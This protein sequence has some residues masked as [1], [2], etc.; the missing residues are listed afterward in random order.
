M[1]VFPQDIFNKMQLSQACK[2]E[3]EKRTLV[4]TLGLPWRLQATPLGSYRLHRSWIE[5]SPARHASFVANRKKSNEKEAE[6]A[7]VTLSTE[8]AGAP[9]RRSESIEQ[10]DPSPLAYKLIA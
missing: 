5:L 1:Q 2:N 8:Q 7:H 3:I 4:H 9:W 10:A 6:A